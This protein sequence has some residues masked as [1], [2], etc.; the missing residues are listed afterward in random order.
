ME[1]NGWEAL[2]ASS[3]SNFF[4]FTGSWLDSHERLQA[5]VPV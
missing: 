2:V 3:P 1:N 5:I 4:Y